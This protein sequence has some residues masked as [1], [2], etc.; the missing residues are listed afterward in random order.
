[1][2]KEQS[3]VPKSREIKMGWLEKA[4]GKIPH[5]TIMFMWLFFFTLVL[6]LV[7]NLLKVSVTVPN[8]GEVV[9][10]VNMLSAAR[11]ADIFKNMGSVFITFTPLL[12]VPLCALGM[13]VANHGGLLSTSMKLVGISK[14]KIMMTFLV[15]LIGANGNLAGDVALIVYPSLVAILFKSCKRNPLAGLFLAYASANAGF[16]ANFLLSAGDASLA[17]ITGAAAAT[18]AKFDASP[19]MGYY[20]M[21]VSAFFLAIILTIIHLKIVEPHLEKSGLG[22]NEEFGEA[23]ID[24]DMSSTETTAVE[25]RGLKNGL[26]ALIAVGVFCAAMCIKGMPFAAPEGGSIMN[27]ALLKSVAALIFFTFLVPGYVYGKTTGKFKKLADVIPAM[28]QEIKTLAPFMV[29][30]FFASQF[31]S[32][33]G[34]SNIATIIA[35]VG[36]NALKASGLSGPI[37][38]VLLIL[39]IALINLVMPSASAKWVLLAPIVVPMLMYSGVSPAAVQV[40]YRM[41]DGIT[42]AITPIAPATAA[43]LVYAQQYDKHANI[44]TIVSRCLPY[45]LL[46]GL[47][48]IIFFFIWCLLGIPVGPG[49]PSFVKF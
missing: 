12:T 39:A 17:G 22:E 20:F 35:V 2:N 29:V 48:W 37:M 4:A 23:E 6:S 33:F 49:Y 19:A 8:T 13:G 21:A 36:G 10:A 9:T 43:I 46:G 11:I 3:T 7:L 24:I 31:I 32:I 18:V 40:A 5:P 30:C 47:A 16:G 44:G 15:A 42:N 45:C 34:T 14:S 28:I 1:M 26:I 25:R 41:A 27:G 38:L